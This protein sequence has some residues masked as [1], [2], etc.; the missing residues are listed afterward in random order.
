MRINEIY[1]RLEAIKH[2]KTNVSRPETAKNSPVEVSK[3]EEIPP[4]KPE[5]PQGQEEKR[6]I[7]GASPRK[8]GKL[9]DI[10]MRKLSFQHRYFFA[11]RL[12]ALSPLPPI[13]PLFPLHEPGSRPFSLLCP[14][15]GATDNFF[16]QALEFGGNSDSDLSIICGYCKSNLEPDKHYTGTAGDIYR[17]L[18]PVKEESPGQ[19]PAHPLIKPCPVCGGCLFWENLNGVI[20]CVKCIPPYNEWA[21]KRYWRFTEGGEVMEVGYEHNYE[22]AKEALFQHARHGVKAKVPV[23]ESEELPF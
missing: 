13:Y 22:K 15:C 18:S 6:V 12:F 4:M 19:D 9:R 7:P 10:S 14:K 11:Y 5:P 16:F 17:K 2:S 23:T 3:S 8:N 1:Q 21:V 20:S